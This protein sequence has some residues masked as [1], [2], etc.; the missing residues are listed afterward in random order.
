MRPL[1]TTPPAAP[2]RPAPPSNL[3]DDFSRR[4]VVHTA[5]LPWQPSPMP[6]VDRRPLDRVGGEVARA[7]SIV[8]YAPGSRFERH[9][10]GGGEEILVLEGTFSDEG[11]DHPAGT[12]LR[13][14]PGSAHAPYSREGCVLFVKLWQFTAGDS[15]AVRIDTRAGGW[16]QGL[17]PG[18]AVLPLH[19]HDGVDTALVRWA[20]DTVFNPHGHPGGEEIL[21]LE[22]VF[23]D[24]GGAYRAGTWLRSPRGSRHAPFTG[25]EGALI[26]VKV[27]H[28]GADFLQP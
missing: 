16:R 24:E 22:G 17:V 19:G 4:T 20:P 6:G 27:G 2:E 3:N 26:Y 28:L 25:P 9:L 23:R 7:T 11:G 21:V 12:Y 14:P 18:L 10:H 1:E 13:N 5:D 8:R 15:E